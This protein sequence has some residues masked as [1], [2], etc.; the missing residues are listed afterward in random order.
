MAWYFFLNKHAT[1]WLQHAAKNW[2]NHSSTIIFICVIVNERKVK[3]HPVYSSGYD[4]VVSTVGLF[5]SRWKGHSPNKHTSRKWTFRQLTVS[6]L[7]MSTIT[8]NVYMLSSSG[9][10]G[11]KQHLFRMNVFIINDEVITMDGAQ[12]Q[13]MLL[14]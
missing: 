11:K 6:V 13:T 4:K 5:V 10:W 8:A 2:G 12:H 14:S 7:T 1:C 9:T 3:Y